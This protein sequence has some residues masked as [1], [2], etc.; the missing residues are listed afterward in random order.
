GAELSSAVEVRGFVTGTRCAGAFLN[1]RAT[2]A[3]EVRSVQRGATKP[4]P[5]LLLRGLATGVNLR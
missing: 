3:V 5:I 4:P 1:Q 2:S